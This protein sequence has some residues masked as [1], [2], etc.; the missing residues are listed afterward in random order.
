ML[1]IILKN[2]RSWGNKTTTVPMFLFFFPG[3][4]TSWPSWSSSRPDTTCPKQLSYHIPSTFP[5][6]LVVSA[7]S[8]APWQDHAS[9]KIPALRPSHLF[10]SSQWLWLQKLKNYFDM[11]IRSSSLWRVVAEWW[12]HGHFYFTGILMLTDKFM[13]N[14]QTWFK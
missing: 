7:Q 6:Q 13:S 11:T 3:G 8:I 1:F 5:Q 10:I 12:W 2:G 9:Q 14:G 4:G